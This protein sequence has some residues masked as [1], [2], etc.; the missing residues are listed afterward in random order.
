M[1]K[2]P[3]VALLPTWRYWV[4]WVQ[5]YLEM[6]TNSLQVSPSTVRATM[7][8]KLGLKLNWIKYL[9]K[10]LH[11]AVAAILK[12]PSGQYLTHLI[13]EQ[14]GPIQVNR[15]KMIKTE[16]APAGIEVEAQVITFDPKAK[17]KRT[18]QELLQ[19][20]E[21]PSEVDLLASNLQAINLQL[22]SDLEASRKEVED[23]IVKR[24]ELVNHYETLL[25]EKQTALESMEH[26][27]AKA[28]VY[29]LDTD[30]RA[31]RYELRKAEDALEGE[32]QKAEGAL[33]GGQSKKDFVAT[34]ESIQIG[35]SQKA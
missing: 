20:V 34:V 28:R 25:Q 7:A 12:D 3:K 8:I 32:L 2:A 22:V 10:R 14:L 31:A 29:D 16:E 13:R 4:Q 21:Q 27:L 9:T 1:K 15:V 17:M 35:N 23:F 5:L 18:L 11:D 24:E 26:Q 30:L 33:E 19:R 6:D